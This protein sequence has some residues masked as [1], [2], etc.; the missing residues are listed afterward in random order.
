MSSFWLNEQLMRPDNREKVAVCMRLGTANSLETDCAEL[1]QRAT[2]DIDEIWRALSP[3]FRAKL[4][5]W[6]QYRY[7]LVIGVDKDN[8]LCLFPVD[9]ARVVEGM[10]LSEV[11]FSDAIDKRIFWLI[12]APVYRTSENTVRSIYGINRDGGY[13]LTEQTRW[14]AVTNAYLS[15]SIQYFDTYNVGKEYWDKYIH[16]VLN[17]EYG[18]SNAQVDI[19]NSGSLVD[20]GPLDRGPVNQE[21]R[22]KT[23]LELA[24]NID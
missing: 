18:P 4:P 3:Y 11:A 6:S 10:L 24:E 7:D 8:R 2:Q 20:G 1:N 17:G 12:T 16:T 21:A 23:L 15:E 14:G 13:Q 22:G 5:E 19:M 9:S